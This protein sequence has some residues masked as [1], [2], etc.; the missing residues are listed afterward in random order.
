MIDYSKKYSLILLIVLQITFLIAGGD[1]Y[2]R[3]K[4][5]DPFKVNSV[6]RIGDYPFP[7]N[8][9]NDRAIGYLLQGKIN[10]GISNYGNI[11]NWDEQPSGLWGDYSYLPSVAFLAGVPGH[12]R[13]SDFQWLSVESVVDNEGFVLYSIWE[14]QSAYE[15]WHENGDTN[16]VG[17]LS[18]SYTHLTLPTKRIV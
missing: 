13:T 8:P 7:T 12:K 4:V 6:A 17:I 10:N 3:E 5:N 1:K 18:V 14:S 15:A 16:F 2:E 11:I 9:M